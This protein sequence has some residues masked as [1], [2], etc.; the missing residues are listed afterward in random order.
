MRRR[1]LESNLGSSKSSVSLSASIAVQRPSYRAGSRSRTIS[2][3]ATFSAWLPA[4]GSDSGSAPI[5]LC[6]GVSG[7]RPSMRNSL[8]VAGAFPGGW[9]C[10]W[11]CARCASVRS[12]EDGEGATCMNATTT[13]SKNAN[14][15]ESSIMRKTKSAAPTTAI[16]SCSPTRSKRELKT[17]GRWV[18]YPSAC[19]AARIACCSATVNFR[20]SVPWKSCR[21]EGRC[22]VLYKKGLLGLGPH[23]NKGK[24]PNNGYA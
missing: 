16:T 20:R 7:L 1:T 23:P 4:G 5:S 9:G 13:P 18:S 15:N 21:P 19:S 6:A 12:F 22:C 8:C 24:I 17:A 10:A 11:A 14:A 2:A 3:L